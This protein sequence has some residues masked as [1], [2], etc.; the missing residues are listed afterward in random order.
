[1]SSLVVAFIIGFLLF[2]F[3]SLAYE[4]GNPHPDTLLYLSRGSHIQEKVKMS[5]HSINFNER[6]A[7]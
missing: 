7:V 6:I 1:M 5:N 3:A 2:W 4:A